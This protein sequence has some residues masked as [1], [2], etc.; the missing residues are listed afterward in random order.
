MDSSCPPTEGR[1]TS[2]VTLMIR[3]AEINVRSFDTNLTVVDY[4]H[5]VQMG[6][7]IKHNVDV[8]FSELFKFGNNL[9]QI[10]QS[11]TL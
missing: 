1:L 5:Q 6:F 8:D 7:P 10:N 11:R 3:G 4:L 2:N 9:E